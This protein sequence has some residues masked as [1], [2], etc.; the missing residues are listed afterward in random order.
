MKPAEKAAIAK[1]VY[2][3]GWHARY[4]AARLGFCS[5]EGCSD[6]IR[7][8]VIQLVHDMMTLRDDHDSELKIGPFVFVPYAERDTY[9]ILVTAFGRQVT[10]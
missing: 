7:S 1:I 6:D 4:L 8:R 5:S 3:R 10:L 2:G 9:E